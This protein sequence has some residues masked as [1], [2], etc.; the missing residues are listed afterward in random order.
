M[1]LGSG[2][3]SARTKMPRPIPPQT[4]A[5]LGSPADQPRP[6]TEQPGPPTKAAPEARRLDMDDAL[7]LTQEPTTEPGR[8]RHFDK[9]EDLESSC[10][11]GRISPTP[12]PKEAP[13]TIELPPLKKEK[14]QAC[15]AVSFESKDQEMPDKELESGKAPLEPKDQEMPDKELESGKAPLEP[16]DKHVKLEF[17]DGYDIQDTDFAFLHCDE[18]VSEPVVTT[19]NVL[20]PR[21]YADLVERDAKGEKSG[22]RLIDSAK[23]FAND[24]KTPL[25][26][27]SLFNSGTTGLRRSASRSL[28]DILNTPD[29][30]KRPPV[31]KRTPSSKGRCSMSQVD[32]QVDVFGEDTSSDDEDE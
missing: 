3:G 21:F 20:D 23:K 26:G 6:P 27:S 7:E 16:N 11:R 12:S 13:P 1:G 18:K 25:K 15:R 24:E 9:D 32:S 29:T 2:H 30:T 4:L 10:K 8:K 19:Y 17:E 22:S 28:A 5:T 14:A 31:D